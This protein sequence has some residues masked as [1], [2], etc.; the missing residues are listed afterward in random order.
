MHATFGAFDIKMFHFFKLPFEALFKAPTTLL[1]ENWLLFPE[2]VNRP[3]NTP[4]W[5]SH[6]A[7]VRAA[8]SLRQVLNA[9]SLLGNDWESSL[10]TE[11]I[12]VSSRISWINHMMMD[13]HSDVHSF[14]HF[15]K[16]LSGII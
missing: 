16:T 10:I 12:S 3:L 6:S 8:L 15:F 11:V 14:V 7:T 1:W 13:I 5:L 9:G 2:G 4:S